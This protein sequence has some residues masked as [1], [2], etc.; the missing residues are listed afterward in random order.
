MKKTFFITIT[1]LLA[2]NSLVF[3]QTYEAPKNYSLKAKEDYAPY[4][5]DVIRAIDWLEQTRWADQTEKRDEVR[6]FVMKWIIGSP[7]VSVEINAEVLKLSKKDAELMGSY[8]Y[9]FAK[10][11]LLHKTDYDATQAK[12]A[13]LRGVI[14]KYTMET[15][16]KKN[17]EIEKLIKL[18]QDGKLEAWVSTDFNKS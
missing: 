8:M 18:E 13:G 11:A 15:G 10:Y 4:E 3:A 14:A 2:I 5:Q 7:S 6:A 17:S 9:G 1:F 12:L 16:H